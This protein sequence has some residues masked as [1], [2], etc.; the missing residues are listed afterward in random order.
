MYPHRNG[1]YTNADATTTFDEKVDIIATR[2]I[3]AGET[4]Y[5]SQNLCG[6]CEQ[7]PRGYGTA[8]TTRFFKI[9]TTGSD[10]DAPMT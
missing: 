9:L 8:G 3:Q 6:E 7:R 10:C 1:D 2:D 5:L 4:I